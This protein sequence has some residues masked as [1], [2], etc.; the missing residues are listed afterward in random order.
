VTSK[1]LRLGAVRL[2]L[3]SVSVDF[4]P[5][6]RTFLITLAGLALVLL[7][8][9][10]WTGAPP[11]AGR[12]A[13]M[14]DAGRLTGLLAGYVAICQLLLRSRL[15]VVERGFGTDAINDLHRVFGGYLLALVLAHATLVTA[16]Y[17]AS[18]RT[19]VPQ[20][21]WTLITSYPYV[22]WAAAAL[23][24]LLTVVAVSI[25]LIRR[26]LRYEVWHGIHALVYVAVILAFFHQIAV[27][28]HF[29]RSGTLKTA[30]TYAG[31][32]VGLLI[33]ASR[34]LRPI[35]LVA[36]HR[37]AVDRIVQESPGV[38]S[39]WMSGRRLDQFYTAGQ[40]CRWRF[41]TRGLFLA[42]HPYSMST[43]PARDFLRVTAR[44]TG[45]HGVKLAHLRPGTLVVPEGPCGGLTIPRWTRRPVVLIAG[46]IGV[47]P[48]R[49]LF[50]TASCTPGELALIYR[51]KGESDVILRDELDRLAADKGGRVH[52]LIGPRTSEAAALS[53]DRLA[54][55][56]PAIAN[57]QVFV[58][59]SK[60]FVDHVRRVLHTVPV[61]RSRIHA[62][63]FEM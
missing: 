53:P 36:R 25:R 37:L 5:W 46:G 34:F 21:A 26:R 52:Y 63:S 41:V 62:E 61:P 20:E 27:G 59:G 14:T 2:P 57:A 49:S 47:T 43:E 12:G 31:V 10:W 32:A 17:S 22:S 48:L 55:L 19:N 4:G 39:I 54:R 58:C 24:I 1:A 40:Y 15:S 11:A 60:G 3:P 7:I 13:R 51:A 28:D 42:A 6:R 56:C 45:D 8:A 38:V 16:G 23:G 30:W 50:G 33:L 35:Y 9:V 44:A 18:A 29:R